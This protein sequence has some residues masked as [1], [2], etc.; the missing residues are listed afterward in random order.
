MYATGIVRGKVV[1]FRLPE[2][3]ARA[4]QRNSGR[5]MTSEEAIAFVEAKRRKLALQRARPYLE[6]RS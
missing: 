6:G 1:R 4:H 3:L 5:S 2:A